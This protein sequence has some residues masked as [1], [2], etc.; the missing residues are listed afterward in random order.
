MREAVGCEKQ[1]RNCRDWSIWAP[2]EYLPEAQGILGGEGTVL[3]Y[4]TSVHTN[5]CVDQNLWNYT[6]KKDGFYLSFFII[7]SKIIFL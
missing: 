6:L 1:Q 2:S 5:V 7:V 4:D 3:D